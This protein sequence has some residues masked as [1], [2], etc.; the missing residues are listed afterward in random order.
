MKTKTTQDGFMFAIL[1]PKEAKEN[2]ESMD[3]FKIFSDNTEDRIE[4][5]ND[6]NDAIDLNISIGY[7]IGRKADFLEEF[8]EG[9]QN[10]F[11]NNN[12]ISFNEWLEQKIDNLI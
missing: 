9:E 10:R 7:E 3:L 12:D 1:E 11:R 5:L 8:Q 2:F 4:S 6:L